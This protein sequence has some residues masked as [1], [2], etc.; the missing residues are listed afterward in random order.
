[1]GVLESLLRCRP[2]LLP[3]LPEPA[4]ELDA[5]TLSVPLARSDAWTLSVPR[6]RL[7]LLSPLRSDCLGRASTALLGLS[8]RLMSGDRSS[9][10]GG[11]RDGRRRT[12]R[13]GC[14]CGPPC[15]SS[16]RL[17]VN[18]VACCRVGPASSPCAALGCTAALPRGVM[19]LSSPALEAA[20]GTG[21]FAFFETS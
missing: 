18:T 15:L 8:R 9:R 12:F 7:S 3:A 2:C 5:L 6:D 16:L 19:T 14:D 11:L 21:G 13:G 4:R 17:E 20:P 10:R 1:M